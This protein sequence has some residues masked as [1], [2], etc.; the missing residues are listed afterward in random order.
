MGIALVGDSQIV[1]LDEPTSGMDAS[2]RRFLWDLLLQEK[3]HR[4]ILITTHFMEEADVTCFS[5]LFQLAL[6]I[7]NYNF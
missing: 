7:F 3:K 4:S 6:I 2:A 5:L 1:I